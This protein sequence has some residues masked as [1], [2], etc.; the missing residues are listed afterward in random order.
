MAEFKIAHVRE[1]EQ[2]LIIVFVNR[3]P[4]A[5][6]IEAL[7]QCASAASLAGTVIPVWRVGL[8]GFRYR[9]PHE[10][11]SFFAH[12]AWDQLVDSADQVLSCG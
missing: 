11:H 4:G 12:M 1:Q 2:D 7:Q 9:A 5:D 3:D 10:W 8:T 6:G